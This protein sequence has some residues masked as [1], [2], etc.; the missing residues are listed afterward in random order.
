MFS[1]MYGMQ[2]WNKIFFLFFIFFYNCFDIWQMRQCS[3]NNDFLFVWNA[4]LIIY[5]EENV[6]SFNRKTWYKIILYNEFKKKKFLK[7]KFFKIMFSFMYGIQICI[8]KYFFFCKF[9]NFLDIWQ[10]RLMTFAT[11]F[12]SIYISFNLQVWNLRSMRHIT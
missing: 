5:K 7:K 11:V 12:V 1:F 4:N 8:K 10:M 9:H 2:I 3:Q 6:S